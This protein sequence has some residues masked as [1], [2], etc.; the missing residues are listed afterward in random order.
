MYG[1]GMF[2][3]NPPWTLHGVL[4]EVMPYLVRHLGQDGQAGYTLEHR[5]Q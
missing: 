5:E 4:Q 3:L 1:S 2:V